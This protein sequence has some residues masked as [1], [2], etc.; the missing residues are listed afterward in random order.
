MNSVY[1]ALDEFSESSRCLIAL[2]RDG[3]IVPYSASP[4]QARATI[5]LRQLL[6]RV[7]MLP[8]LCLAI[9]SAR[10]VAQLRS[11]V[12]GDRIILAGNYGVEIMLQDGRMIVEPQAIAAVPSLKELRDNLFVAVG[13]Y[14]GL[15]LEDHGYSLCLHWHLVSASEID[16]VHEAVR[17]IADQYPQLQ[18]VARATSYEFLPGFRWNKGYA[19]SLIESFLP[20][21]ETS[22]LFAG[23]TDADTPAFDWINQRHGLSIRVGEC[24]NLGA[25]FRVSTPAQLHALLSYFVDRRLSHC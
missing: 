24:D 9:I 23:D 19:L 11:D 2:D 18:A 16:N 1:Q 8:G 6:S 22:F 7:A 17:Q 10:S 12:D 21:S 20:E 3:T 5:E 13:K 25:Q 15:I 4:E 14:R